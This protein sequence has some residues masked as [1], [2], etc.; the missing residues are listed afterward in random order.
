MMPTVSGEKR[1]MKMKIVFFLLLC[2]SLP[3]FAQFKGSGNTFSYGQEMTITVPAGLTGA[4]D[5][6][7]A[8]TVKDATGACVIT[9]IRAANQTESGQVCAAMATQA[10]KIIPDLKVNEPKSGQMG[11]N[12]LEVQDGVGT[13]E[14]IPFDV[15]VGSVHNSTRYLCFFS[16]LSQ[17]DMARW[18][19]LM[20]SLMQSI[21][22]G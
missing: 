13:I 21:K 3:S 20:K 17:A 1:A 8:L 15:T 19:P 7:G 12:T 11:S 6:D 18:D 16:L 4:V 5:E 10:K 22:F 14:K 2:L 9:F